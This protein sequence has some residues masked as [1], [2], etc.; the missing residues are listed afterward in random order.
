METF[1]VAGPVRLWELRQ[2]VHWFVRRRQHFRLVFVTR[3]LIGGL[4]PAA[5]QSPGLEE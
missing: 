1:I 4:L 5:R 2:P 3:L